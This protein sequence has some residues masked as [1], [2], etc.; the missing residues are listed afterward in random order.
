MTTSPTLLL[1]ALLAGPAGEPQSVTCHVRD[2]ARGRIFALEPAGEGPNGWRLSLQDRDSSGKWI[3]L[4][5]PGAAP[6][7]GDGTAS[8]VYKNANGGRQVNFNVKPDRATIDVYVDH[9][10][11]VNIEPDLD[12]G[13][14]RM[15]TNGPLTAL[16][17]T[18]TRP[19]NM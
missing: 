1:L 6:V 12:P 11:E 16:D 15:N 7:F 19:G 5:L 18:V 13:V 17:C 8:L 9:G 10:L 4:A 3:R 2:D 14:D